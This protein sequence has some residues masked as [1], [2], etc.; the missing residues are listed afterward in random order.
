MPC[1]TRAK[2]SPFLH[3]IP[4]W[5][6]NS[7]QCPDASVPITVNMTLLL[8]AHEGLCTPRAWCC[9]LL[10][11]V[12]EGA[13]SRWKL[14]PQTGNTTCLCHHGKRAHPLSCPP[15]LC[16][17]SSMA[18]QWLLSASPGSSWSHPLIPCPVPR[19]TMALPHG[20]LCPV[21][22][23]LAHACAINPILDHE[24]IPSVAA[25]PHHPQHPGMWVPTESIML[26]V[27]AIS[28]RGLL[29]KNT[30]KLS[31]NY[32]AVVFT[33]VIVKMTSNLFLGV[34]LFKFQDPCFNF[35]A[36]CMYVLH[37]FLYYYCPVI[38][39]SGAALCSHPFLLDHLQEMSF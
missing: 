2:P 7:T 10:V 30:K 1:S 20:V 23:H 38:D 32:L 24:T 25:W 14:A 29:F 12:W 26:S 17:V 27:V 39:H 31:V 37:R 34:C 35:P 6:F 16:W 3:R 5:S 19:P 8:K 4:C 15:P 33:N 13:E 28:N 22:P 21:S 36:R 18:S 9:I 11:L